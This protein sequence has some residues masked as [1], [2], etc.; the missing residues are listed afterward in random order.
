MMLVFFAP[1][2]T[3][4]LSEAMPAAPAPRQTIFAVSSVLPCTRRALI[5]PAQMMVAVPCWS[6]WNTGMSSVFFSAASISK[7]CGAAISSRLIPPKV[8]AIAT[9]TLMKSCGVLALTSMS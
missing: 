8:G 5:R 2:A 6:S 1:I 9:T 3:S 7:Q 4:R